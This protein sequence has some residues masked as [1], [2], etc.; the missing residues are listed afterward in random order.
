VS[1]LATVMSVAERAPGG[2]LV[3]I[4]TSICLTQSA[5]IGWVV[6][7]IITGRLVPGGERDYWRDFAFEEQAQKREM[8]VPT[9][10]VIRGMASGLADVT[11]QDGEST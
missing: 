2:P 8:L 11:R 10:Q 9:A 5:L 3:A 4:L 1:L 6:R 7:L